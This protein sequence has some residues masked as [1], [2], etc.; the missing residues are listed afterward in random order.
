MSELARAV[1]FQRVFS[2]RLVEEVVSAPH[3]RGLL[4]PSLPRVFYLNHLSV[5]LGAAASADELVEEAEAVHAP[6][7]LAHRKIAID[8]ELGAAV[9]PRFRELGW[10]VERL[11]VMPHLGP[12]PTVDTSAVDEVDPREL[13]P[14]WTEGI[15]SSPE[16]QDEEEVQQLV[17]A[18]HRRRQAVRVRY[19]A[20]RVEGRI[21]S[22]CE[23]F[24]DGRTGQI[25]SVMTLEPS[26]GRGLAT[27]VVSRA[28]HESQQ[29]HDFTFLVADADDWPKELYRKLGFEERG[30]IWDF[31]RP[32][33]RRDAKESGGVSV[34]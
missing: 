28:L 22:Y 34:E 9:E 1:E 7:G 3:G 21:A 23:L 30:S 15:R 5:D 8:D 32:P 13:E 31:L 16:I 20:A 6:A 11:L 2:E 12:T 27:V 25:E 10:K 24:S 33:P 4:T 14:I 29:L 17:T 18:Q 19:F 26:R